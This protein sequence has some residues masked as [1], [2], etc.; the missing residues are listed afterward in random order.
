MLSACH[1][2]CTQPSAMVPLCYSCRS[3]R[4]FWALH[5]LQTQSKRHNTHRRRPNPPKKTG[6]RN[7]ST[8]PSTSHL[9][10]SRHRLRPLLPGPTWSFCCHPQQNLLHLLVLQLWMLGVSL[11]SSAQSTPPAPSPPP[12]ST[13][14]RSP[15]FCELMRHVSPLSAGRGRVSAVLGPALPDYLRRPTRPW[16]RPAV[17]PGPAG[18]R[19]LDWTCQ[20]QTS[21]VASARPPAASSPTSATSPPLSR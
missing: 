15:T 5:Q 10:S 7:R 18:R 17:S 1:K 3:P 12:R 11:P 14:V 19:S 4:R 2:R 20:P 8:P 6:L 13:V 16:R 9:L 21:P